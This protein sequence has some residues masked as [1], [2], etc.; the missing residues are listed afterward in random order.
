VGGVDEEA[1]YYTVPLFFLVLVNFDKFS[2]HHGKIVVRGIANH[3]FIWTNVWN[4]NTL[5]CVKISLK[6]TK[7][8]DERVNSKL[9]LVVYEV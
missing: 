7:A 5:K 1:S 9:F 6:V 3:H 4:F 8:M 2:C